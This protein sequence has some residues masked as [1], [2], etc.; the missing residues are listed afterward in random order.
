MHCDA[1]CSIL[2]IL[3]L[4]HNYGVL[5]TVSNEMKLHMNYFFI[6]LLIEVSVEHKSMIGGKIQH[7]NFI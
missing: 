3:N 1:R 5:L 6:N 7:T 4:F 2:I